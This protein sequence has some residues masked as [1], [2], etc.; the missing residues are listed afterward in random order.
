M[1]TLREKIETEIERHRDDPAGASLAVCVLLDRMLDLSGN[2]WFDR[3]RE[4]LAALGRDADET[5]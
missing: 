3:D 4:V 2:G 5:E 1:P